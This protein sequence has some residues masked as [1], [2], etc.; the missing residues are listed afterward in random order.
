MYSSSHLH[1]F[2]S[3]LHTISRGLDS[4]RSAEGIMKNRKRFLSI[5]KGMQTE[6]A[7]R[8]DM[9]MDSMQLLQEA[10]ILDPAHRAK[11]LKLLRDLKEVPDQ[12]LNAR[13]EQPRRDAKASSSSCAK[14]CVRRQHKVHYTNIL[15]TWID[16]H[17]KNPYPTKMEKAELCM[18][19]SITE[20]QLNT[21]FT[22]YRRRHLVA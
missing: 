4:E 15:K 3:D 22:N 10:H 7:S 2:A 13:D 21:W 1:S 14:D 16:T 6:A 5:Y 18:K 17:V 11:C 9:D 19:A 12:G 8:T 20:R